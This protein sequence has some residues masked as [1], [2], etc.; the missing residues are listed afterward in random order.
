MTPAQAIADA[1]SLAKILRGASL[2]APLKKCKEIVRGSIK[3]NF[4]S[5]T[6]PDGGAWPKRKPWPGDDGHPLLDDTGF[7][8][9]AAL[10]LG[11]GGFDEIEQRSMSIGIDTSVDQGGIPFADVHDHGIGRMPERHFFA[12]TELALDECGE[13]IGDGMHEKLLAGNE[14]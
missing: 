12:A 9:A 4:D 1:R 14:K 6:A 5:A 11:P 2:A 10:G 7:L 8:K 3:G 13:V